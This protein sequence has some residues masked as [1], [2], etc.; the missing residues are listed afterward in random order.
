[1]ALNRGN[2]QDVLEAASHVQMVAV[3]Q[4]CSSYLKTQI[5][6][7]NCVDI[8]TIAEIYSLSQLRM[9]VYRY[10]S[11]HLL[12]FSSSSEF[13]RLTPQQLENLLA[14][15]FPVDCS[16]ADVLRTVLAWF[17]HVDTQE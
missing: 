17:F 14:Y 7:E 9:K 12:E 1:M 13:Y 3:I 16:E 4:A 2:V 15:D 5:D 8:A 6:I 11:G 10:M